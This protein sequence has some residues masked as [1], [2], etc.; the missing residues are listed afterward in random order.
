[1][2]IWHETKVEQCKRGTRVSQKAM[3]AVKHSRV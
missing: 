3:Q 2:I 1:M